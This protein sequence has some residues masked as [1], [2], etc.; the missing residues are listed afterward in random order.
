MAAV[1]S[2]PRS[3][4]SHGSAAL[5]ADLPTWRLPDAACHTVS[6]LPPSGDS[7]AGHLHRAR[8]PPEQVRPGLIPRTVVAR[9]VADIA[10][11]HGLWDA[12]VAGDAALQRGCLTYEAL[13]DVVAGCVRWPGIRRARGLAVLLDGRSESPLESVSR[14]LVS[15]LGFPDPV[16]QAK[17]AR[18]SGQVV[19]RVDLFWDDVGLVGE[20]DGREKY[21][22]DG[23]R[24]ADAQATLHEQRRRQERLE[25]LGLVV[26]RWGIEEINRP[27]LL[28]DKLRS[29]FARATA[30]T[31]GRRLWRTVDAPPARVV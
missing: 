12:V 7:R 29:G 15:R 14:L 22:I 23:D 10:R 27:V 3:V 4:A 26:V 25:D 28:A 2:V 11:E 13:E 16:L 21:R 24:V 20:V 5:L 1:L 8:I 6:P 31:P 9:T 30:R 17:I 18:P 19:A